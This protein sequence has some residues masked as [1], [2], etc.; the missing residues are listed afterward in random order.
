MKNT[1]LK[2]CLTALILS[3]AGIANA[4]QDGS[5][6]IFTKL[7]MSHAVISGGTASI[8]ANANVHL[9]APLIVKDIATVAA[10][11]IGTSA[12]A[13]NI[14]TGAAF[15]VG[16]NSKLKD[17]YHGA[18]FKLD[19]AMTVAAGSRLEI[20]NTG[21][22]NAVIPV[23]NGA[24]TM[25]VGAS[26][27]GSTLV[28]G[29]ANVATSVLADLVVEDRGYSFPPQYVV[30]NIGPGGGTIVSFDDVA[31]LGIEALQCGYGNRVNANAC[32]ADANNDS[33]GT[34]GEWKIL[35]LIEYTKNDPYRF[36]EFF[37]LED[38]KI[39]IGNYRG[40]EWHGFVTPKSTCRGYYCGWGFKLHPNTKGYIIMT[41]EVSIM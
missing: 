26:F 24:L 9:D 23:L 17:V 10:V 38:N 13:N 16:A 2:T 34:Q 41:R 4:Q 37:S 3:V 21:D 33:D 1:L 22:S 28:E 6:N 20:I 30:G 19:G 7:M 11:G 14:H 35:S 40:N 5:V 12:E 15:A 8:V 39:I 29:A 18:A 31:D 25:G 32:V 36:Q 27:L